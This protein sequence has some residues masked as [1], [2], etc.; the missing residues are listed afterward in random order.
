[1]EASRCLGIGIVMII[2]SF[3]GS[4]AVWA[5]FNR[6]LAVIL[7]IVVMVFIYGIILYKGLNSRR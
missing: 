1:M 3:I 4:G 7:W 6:W 5:V 2:P